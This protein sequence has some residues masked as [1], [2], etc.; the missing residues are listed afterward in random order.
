MNNENEYYEEKF[1]VYS[2]RL[3][4][5]HQSLIK[6]VYEHLDL[7]ELTNLKLTVD[8]GLVANLN[9][10]K[11]CKECDKECFEEKDI[12]KCRTCAYWIHDDASYYTYNEEYGK[13]CSNCHEGH[14]QYLHE[15]SNY[16]EDFSNRREYNQDGDEIP[17]FHHSYN[18]DPN[19][20]NSC[21]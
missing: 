10:F 4:K 1:V 5:K 21:E 3:S 19:P 16:I 18:S 7:K 17:E 15:R 2:R 6:H 13:C 20:T 11:T 8:V 9:F 12:V 14:L